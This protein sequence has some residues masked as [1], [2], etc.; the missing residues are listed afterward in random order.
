MPEQKQYL[1][2]KEVCARLGITLPTLYRYEREKGFPSKIRLNARKVLYDA[3]EINAWINQHKS[4]E[5]N[6]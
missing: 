6:Q 5:G 2:P 3:Q 4:T 1:R